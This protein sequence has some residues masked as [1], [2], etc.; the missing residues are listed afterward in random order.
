MKEKITIVRYYGVAVYLGE[1][2]IWQTGPGGG[3]IPSTLLEALGY[4]VQSLDIDW[5]DMPFTTHGLSRSPYAPESLSI[6]LNHLEEKKQKKLES[7][8]KNAREHLARLERE[9]KDAR[10]TPH[11]RLPESHQDGD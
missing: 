11:Q 8:L 6:L 2:L 4:G 1:K 5:E 7:D 10:K 3:Y 9:V